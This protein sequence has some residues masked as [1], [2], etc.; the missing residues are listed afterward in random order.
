MDLNALSSAELKKLQ[1][2]VHAAIEMRAK[3]DMQEARKAAE[4]AVGGYGFSL[5]EI[6][7]PL[8]SRKKGKAVSKYRNPNNP[9]QTWTGR[10]RKPNWLTEA[11]QGGADLADLEIK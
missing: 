7:P 9:D 4:T 3:T 1:E 10:G 2:D 6:F 11:L 5:E 8:P